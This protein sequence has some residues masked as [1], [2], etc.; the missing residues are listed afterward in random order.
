MFL[1][2]IEDYIYFYNYQCFQKRLSHLATIKY[3]QQMTAGI[4]PHGVVLFLFN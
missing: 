1:L 4:R 3:R 2:V